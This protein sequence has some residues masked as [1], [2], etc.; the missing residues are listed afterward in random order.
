MVYTVNNTSCYDYVFN[1]C[2]QQQT[3]SCVVYT[4]NNNSTY[5]TSYLQLGQIKYM[6]W[7]PQIILFHC[8]STTKLVSVLCIL[9]LGLKLETVAYAQRR[10]NIKNQ[11]LELVNESLLVVVLTSFRCS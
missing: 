5:C 1:V 2:M 8:R 9:G 4:V 10:L 6:N 11:I 3:L 7:W